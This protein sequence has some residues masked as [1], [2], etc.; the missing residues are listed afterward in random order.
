MPDDKCSQDSA[1]RD[2]SLQGQDQQGQE[3]TDFLR[4]IV[5][6][7]LASGRVESSR[8]PL[9]PGTQR[10]PPHRPRQVHLPEFRHRQAVRRPVQPAHG[11]HQPHQRRRGVRR[12]H[13]RRRQV[14]HRRLGRPSAGPQAGRR[15]ARRRH[16]AL[17]RGRTSTCPRSCPP[18][19][20]AEIVEPFYASDYFEPLYAYAL[21]LI[22]KGKA[23]VCDHTA[24]EIDAMRGSTDTPRQGEPVPEPLH[25]GEPRPVPA[26]ARRRVPRRR[27]HPAGQD[28]HGRAQRLAAR[29]GA[30]TASATRPTITPATP[31][32]STPCTTSPTA[33]PTTSRASPTASAPSSS[34]CTARSTTGSSTPSTWRA[35]T[36][37]SASSPASTSP[38]PS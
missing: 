21:E 7:D 2:E 31:G 18:R 26:H 4:E 19:R 1:T 29:P 30:C 16:D 5:Q 13:H 8:H 27:P 34:R 38:T 15:H 32:A 23:F 24:E 33:C 37:S 14:A 36:P 22:R 12:L 28:R 17:R 11:R 10:L 3:K 20:P 35:S 9:S 6:Q 25:R